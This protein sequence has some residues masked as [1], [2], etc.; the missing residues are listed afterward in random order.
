MLSIKDYN[1]RLE[2]KNDESNLNSVGNCQITY[3][4]FVFPK[5]IQLDANRRLLSRIFSNLVIEIIFKKIALIF[6]ENMI[7]YKIRDG[8]I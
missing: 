5:E 8:L 6:L 1:F 2:M 3:K 4:I 7:D